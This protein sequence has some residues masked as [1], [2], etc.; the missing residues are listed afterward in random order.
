MFSL[1][2]TL[3]H[4]PNWILT[5]FAMVAAF[6]TYFCMYA[7]RKPFSA[8]TYEGLTLFD[9]D[10]TL[11]TTFVVAQLVG[12]T[13]SKIIGIKVCSEANPNSRTKWLIGLILAAEFALI[14]FAVLP[15][16][17]KIIAIFLNGMPL[18]MVFGLV[19]SYLEGRRTSEL[20]LAGLNCSFIVAS[21]VVKDVGRWV[22]R[23]ETLHMSEFTMPAVT[24]L[25]FL[26]PFVFSVWLL[27]LIP[28]P[29]PRDVA[30]RSAR[31]PMNRE[32]RLAFARRFSGG[33]IPLIVAYVALTAYRDF[34][35]NYGIEIFQSLG[36]GSDLTIFSR[37]ELWVA[38]GVM[39][40]MAMIAFID[41]HKKGLAAAFALMVCGMVIL[42]SATLCHQLG[43][44]SGEHWMVLTGV[45]SY[46]AY[47]PFNAV[48]FERVFA[49]TRAIGNA[50]FVIYLSD[51]FGYVG[52]ICLLFFKDLLMGNSSH[53]SFFINYT[54]I[55]SIVGGVAFTASMIFFLRRGDKREQNIAVSQGAKTP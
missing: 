53:L 27:S 29:S 18:G 8:G 42:G 35:D 28:K 13:L 55:M 41:D 47:V 9:T 14:L 46:L 22:M 48:L 15:I 11:K 21:G 51:S 33:L 5:P 44:L 50:V 23:P 4:A 38:F 30:D 54:Y 45:G 26:I 10:L 37:T 2:Q 43:F 52:S 40:G 24:G 34:R 7:F 20:L 17:F 12:Y 3:K 36:Y 19:V 31:D 16:D 32:T 1:R 49:Y 6:S 25:L 39:G